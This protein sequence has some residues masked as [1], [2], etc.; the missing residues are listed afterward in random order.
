M[1]IDFVIVS[2]DDNPLYS[3]F[4]PVVKNLWSN[5]VGIKPILVKI[6]DT[7]E[8]IESDECIIH[9]LKKVDGIKTGLQSQIA[10][11]FVTKYYKD[12]VCLTSDI[13]MLPLSKKYFTSDI[14]NL[15]NDSM[16][17]FSSDAYKN[18]NRY[19]IC[20]N[21]G[22]GSLF[23]EI[24]QLDVSFEEYC[25]RLLSLGWG[26]GT[27][28]LYFGKM[29]NSYYDQSKITKLNRGW[30][31]GVAKDRLDRIRWKYDPNNFKDQ[32]IDS[33]SLRPYSTHKTQIDK[34]VNLVL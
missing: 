21:A 26:W 7:D 22:K 9:N 24:L 6:S 16:V 11:M 1:K 14:E 25:N 29:I 23:S 13:D 30:S 27:D 31:F 12:S 33:H 20:Y 17:I 19:P 32:F 15:N 34:I 5:L 2:T 28:E 4:W 8:I 10:R 3:E 18:V